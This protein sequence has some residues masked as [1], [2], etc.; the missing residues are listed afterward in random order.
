MSE[1]E[2]ELNDGSKIVKS[3]RVL[4]RMIVEGGGTR[5]LG[6]YVPEALTWKNPDV[7]VRSHHIELCYVSEKQLNAWRAEYDAR[8]KRDQEE[9]ER[10]LREAEEDAKLAEQSEPEEIDSTTEF[11]EEKIDLG[12]VVENEDE[13]SG[14]EKQRKIVIKKGSE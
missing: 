7:W 11:K 2:P 1:I 10:V 14:D 5:L 12:P 3:Y 6:D 8:V 4:K 13:T 9:V